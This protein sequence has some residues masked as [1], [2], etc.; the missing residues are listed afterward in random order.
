LVS[1]EDVCWMVQE[2]MNSR[3]DMCDGLGRFMIANILC[4][5]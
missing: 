3:I 5:R 4:I 2:R 1:S